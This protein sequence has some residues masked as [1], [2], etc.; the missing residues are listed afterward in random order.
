MGLEPDCS[1]LGSDQVSREGKRNK[2]CLRPTT[3]LMHIGKAIIEEQK[4][5]VCGA[6]KW[7]EVTMA[8]GAGQAA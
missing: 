7:V 1:G 8:H 4:K 2:T 5:E 3:Q 6:R